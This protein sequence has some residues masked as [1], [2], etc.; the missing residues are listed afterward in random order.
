NMPMTFVVGPG[1]AQA[2]TDDGTTPATDEIY[3][4]GNRTET[5]WSEA[6]GRNGTMYRW[7]QATNGLYRYTN[8]HG[9]GGLADK[10][11][12]VVAAGRAKGWKPYSGPV[13]GQ[14]DSYRWGDP[15]YDCSSFVASMYRDALGISLAGF[16][17]TIATQTDAISQ[18]QALPGDIILY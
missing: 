18:Q 12:E 16:T 15:G 8:G 11:G 5:Q 7:V 3:I 2:M 4:H 13:I 6:L 10:L 14:P 9:G 1:I 17:D